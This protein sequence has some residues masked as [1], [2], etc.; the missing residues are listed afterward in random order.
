MR[1]TLRLFTSLLV[2]TALCAQKTA[3]P[4]TIADSDLALQLDNLV[5][6]N[7][8]TF[9]G[10][11]LVA[12][13]GK[14]VF[15]KGYGFADR[16]KTPLGPQCLFDLGGASQQLLLLATLRLANEQKLRL[17]DSVR[18]F[19]PEWPTE[20]SALSLQDLV[21]HCSGLPALVKWEG[22]S[23]Q[24]PKA[25]IAMLARTPLAGRIGAEVLYS[26]TNANLLALV[27]ETAGQQRF[28]KVLLERALRP[29]GMA[30]AQ[31]LGQR[32]DAKL[33]T[34]RRVP[35]NERGDSLD[36]SEWNWSHRGA[37]GVLAS[38]LDV[39]AL[40]SALVDGKLL[41]DE[42]LVALWRPLVGDSYGV[43]ALPGNGTTFVRVHGH[44]T[45][46]RT[47]WV[48]DRTT[49]S[50]VVILSEDYG[51]TDAVEAALAAATWQA[52]AAAR[53]EAVTP[54]VPAPTPSDPAVPAAWAAGDIERF[55]GSFALP[56][57]GGTFRIERAANGVRL[58]GSGLQ[59]SVR[60]S[61]GFW[62]PPNEARLRTAEDRGLSLLA[63]VLADDA[64]VDAAGFETPS[65]G[66]AARA[67]LRAVVQASGAPTRIEYIGMTQQGHGESW[68]RCVWA[69]EERIVRAA[70]IH[71]TKWV[72]CTWAQEPIP[73][74]VDL[75]FR[76]PDV[77]VATLANGKRILVTMEGRG[78]Q[79]QLV[80]EDASAGHDGLLD[81]PLL[82]SGG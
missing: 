43:T 36:K 17:E 6:K 71:A 9:W 50:W 2:A 72:R 40:L 38:V 14:P 32:V 59:A 34:T 26:P 47:R 74:A 23:A 56:S 48:I 5:T 44:T 75:E 16:L 67:E 68:F 82:P 76:R 66:A 64:T 12:I 29:A 13:D 77:A 80:F 35:G 69:K 51:A 57:G 25:A 81:C 15:A 27:L 37:R 41:P 28:E 46:Y 39:H 53:T 73:F 11:V 70:W 20:R 62:P 31:L 78:A 54:S 65:V 52:V 18:K 45:G 3:P 33:A 63:R 55:V 19:L 42:L 8:S 21:R 58:V 49:R 30:S 79:R 61:V 22:N 1:R 60:L 4:G 7:A 10:A 24:N